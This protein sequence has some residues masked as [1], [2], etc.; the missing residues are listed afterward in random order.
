MHCGQCYVEKNKPNEAILR[1]YSALNDGGVNGRVSWG[2]AARA[3]SVPLRARILLAGA[4]PESRGAPRRAG[5]DY[6]Q[7]D[8]SGAG[9]RRLTRG[10]SEGP[11]RAGPWV[12]RRPGPVIGGAARGAEAVL[13]AVRH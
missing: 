8:G 13:L 5:D 10:A 6:E 11:V 7:P 2:S 9:R 4:S 3:S 12:A 1:L